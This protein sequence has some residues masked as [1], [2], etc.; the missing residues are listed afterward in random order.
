MNRKTR[1]ILLAGIAIVT[2]WLLAWGGYTIAQNSK[3]TAEKLRKYVN[4]VDFAKLSAAD[5]AKALRELAN[6]INALSA[7]ER[8]HWRL[9]QDWKDWFQ[10]MTEDEKAQFI[11]ATLPS[12]FKQMLTSFEQLPEAN[13]RKTIDNVLKKLKEE[14]QMPAGQGG[15]NGSNYGTNG[16]PVLSPELEQKVRAIGLKTFYGESS[17]QTKAE[18]APVLEELQNQMKNGRAFR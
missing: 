14:G 17:A 15:Q 16:A 6:K 12:G 10:D 3:M 9:D 18:L 2:A 1:P 4:S 5:R 13:R 8:R 7:E 11:E